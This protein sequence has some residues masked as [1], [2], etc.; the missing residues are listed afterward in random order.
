MRILIGMSGG[1]DSST[2]ALILKEQGHE[3]IGATMS[4]WG[5]KGIYKK[6]SEQSSNL[7]PKAKHG[8]CLGPDEKEDI[9]AAKKICEEIGIPFYVFDCAE[10]YEKIVLSNFKK[11]YMA[12]R[13]PN[14]CIW[15]NA[16]IKFEALPQLAKANGIRFDKF[17]TGHYAKVE[18]DEKA[19]RY[20]LKKGKSPNKDQSYFL[21][22]LTQKQL[23]NILLPLGDYSKEEIRDIASKNGLSVASKADSQD[24]YEGDYNELLNVKPK[25]GNIVDTKGNILGTHD[26]IWNYT[27]GQRKGLKISSEAPLYVLELDN[28]K[29]EVVV[30]FKNK[31]FKNELIASDLN[32]IAITKPKENFHCK[33]KIRSTQTPVAV[34]IRPNE[35]F[36]TVEF[37]DLQK[38]IAP[39]Q[40]I[41]FYKE[42]IVLGGGVIRS[43]N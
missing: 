36:L 10:Q 22:R 35:D 24:F 28:E 16:L 27:I 4:I 18:F 11:E 34:E 3:V 20:L 13:T 9:E 5:K 42:D 14:P 38:S 31:T 26:G 6:L 33:A 2:A 8:A 25:K 37:E 29:N 1:V 23:A 19:N 17:A 39:G 43:C 7:L 41:V 32:W 30:G 12:G 15:C 21:N 40:A